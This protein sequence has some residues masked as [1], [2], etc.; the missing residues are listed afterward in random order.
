VRL[1]G[2]EILV[3]TTLYKEKQS[4]YIAEQAFIVAHCC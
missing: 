2:A 3:K 4:N 1:E